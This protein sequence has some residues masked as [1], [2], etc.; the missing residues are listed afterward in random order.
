MAPNPAE[1]RELDNKK[2][3]K[4]RHYRTVALAKAVLGL[5]QG[6]G[7]GELGPLQLA[8]RDSY[9]AVRMMRKTSNFLVCR[10]VLFQRSPVGPACT[11]R[12]RRCREVDQW[13][14]ET[15]LRYVYENKA[16]GGYR[17]QMTAAD[18]RLHTAIIT[19]LAQRAYDEH[20]FARDPLWRKMIRFEVR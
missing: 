11:F 15:P 6:V 20:P 13:L 1:V 2:R 10:F 3:W 19:K 8:Y 16:E 4:R 18:V 14:G 12:I 7:G 5:A 17:V 9:I